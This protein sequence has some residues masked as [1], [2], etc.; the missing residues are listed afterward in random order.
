VWAEAGSR[1]FKERRT[2]VLATIVSERLVD[3]LVL[4]LM[5][6]CFALG[7][8]ESARNLI[9]VALAFGAAILAVWL[10]LV[11]RERIFALAARFGERFNHKVSDYLVNRFEVFVNGLSPLA[12]LS[13]LP[14]ITLWS[15]M[16]WFTE[17]AV[18]MAIAEAFQANLAPAHCVLFMVAVNFASLVPAAPGGLGVIE[19]FASGVLRPFVGSRE[20]ALSLVLTQHLIQFLVVGIPGLLALFSLK[21]DVGSV[22]DLSNDG[23]QK[24]GV[25]RVA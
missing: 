8:T 19:A 3:G 6:V 22:K 5:F 20:F 7:L 18:Y 10:A 2:L 9:F 12:K 16:V 21:K 14:A 15:L 24:R 25:Q 13:R 11:R 1:V 23:E 17:L 4:S